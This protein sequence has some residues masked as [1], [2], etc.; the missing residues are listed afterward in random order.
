MYDTRSPAVSTAVG[1]STYLDLGHEGIVL[2]PLEAT[3]FHIR[4]RSDWPR[5]VREAVSLADLASKRVVQ[6]FHYCL[7]D[8]M[9]TMGACVVGPCGSVPDQ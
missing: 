1:A 3:S 9:T 2:E 4:H 7:Q 5:K 6:S 8:L